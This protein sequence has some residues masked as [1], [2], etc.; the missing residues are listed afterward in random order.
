MAGVQVPHAVPVSLT[1]GDRSCFSS[2]VVP[3]PPPPPAT[4]V[5]RWLLDP[6][7]PPPTPGILYCNNLGG[8]ETKTEDF[9][10]H[11]LSLDI[12]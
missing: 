10:N 8:V 12:G 1:T 2:A 11:L 4:P 6:P 7:P 3:V 9:Q 5:A